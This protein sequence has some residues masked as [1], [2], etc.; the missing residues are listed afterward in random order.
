MSSQTRGMRAE[1]ILKGVY[2]LVMTPTSSRSVPNSTA[3][4]CESLCPEER[5][6]AAASGRV[7]VFFVLVVWFISIHIYSSIILVYRHVYSRNIRPD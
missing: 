2:H 7:S 4:C 5:L 6:E 1:V 3:R